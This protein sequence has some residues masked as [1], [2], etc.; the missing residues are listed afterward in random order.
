MIQL[1]YNLRWRQ[2]LPWSFSDLTSVSVPFHFSLILGQLAG[3]LCIFK[4]CDG[5]VFELVC[6][7]CGSLADDQVCCGLVV[8]SDRGVVS[9]VSQGTVF[10]C[11]VVLVLFSP[12]HNALAEGELLATLHPA[13][14]GPRSVHFTGEGHCILLLGVNILQRN[15]KPQ[16]LL[17]KTQTA[18]L[19][20]HL[21]HHC[22]ITLWL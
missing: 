12:V 8:S 2:A 11:Q 16:A 9:F 4:L 19:L 14:F 1:L 13:Q 5:L 20:I 18:M 17:C 7:V 22:V 10:N 3:E 15:H 6:E 21:L